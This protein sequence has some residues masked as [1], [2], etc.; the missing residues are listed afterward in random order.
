M[1]CE[2]LLE[3][4]TVLVPYISI[5]PMSIYQPLYAPINYLVQPVVLPSNSFIQ[6]L[7]HSNSIPYSCTLY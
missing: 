6:F 4:S 1:L 3:V 2:Y 5:T 7:Y